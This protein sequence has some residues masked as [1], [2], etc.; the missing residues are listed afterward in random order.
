MQAL[1]GAGVLL[2]ATEVD[3]APLAL[4]VDNVTALYPV[5]V[6]RIETPQQVQ[7]VVAAVR[8]WP[9][10]IAVG[11]GRFSMGGQVAVAGGLHL[12]LRQMN[13][14]VWLR[15]DERRVRVQAGMSWR[16]LQA[17]LDPLG[18]AVH[19][20]QSYANFTVGGSVSV[21]A[22]G[23]YVGHGP[24]GHSVQAL[25]LV[26]ADGAVMEASRVQH[27][28]LFRAAIGGYGA[29][30]V[31]VEVELAV[32]GNVR[33][34][35]RV[36]EVPMAD[37]LAHF[38]RT[39]RADATSVLHNADLR[40]PRFDRPVC[41]TWHRTEAEVTDPL[42][43]TPHGAGHALQ[44][45]A[46]WAVTELPGGDGLRRSVIDPLRLGSPQ[47]CWLNREASLDVAEL[48]PATRRINTYAL[49]E[50]FIPPRHVEAFAKAMGGV[51]RRHR[52]QAVNVSVRH[53]SAD[54][55]SLLPWAKEEVFSFVLYHKQ[56]TSEEAC[57]AVG[58]WTRALIELA[59]AHDGRYYL[60]Y[61]LH[62]TREQF[63]RAYPEVQALRELKRRVDPTG[64]FTNTLWTRYL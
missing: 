56:R 58:E 15:A 29:V 47:V 59:L 38:D 23:R 8:A 16:A 55:V 20:M 46:L 17:L 40:P 3:A 6:A 2:L 31:I 49:Q 45:T 60:P 61:Q 14:L 62:A 57:A 13:Q 10:A 27:A 5:Q 39:V 21:N 1:A 24:V 43:L 9:G 26:V 48:E 44:K 37:Y 41:V 19:T 12:D 36:T 35:R 7:D 32:T 28:E 30:G 51:L 33:I 22:H 18:L 4:Q 34:E 64:R 54:A 42:R 25:S 11:G 53:T 52:V 63:E 50:Y